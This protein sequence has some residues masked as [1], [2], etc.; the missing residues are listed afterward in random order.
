MKRRIVFLAC[1][2]ILA[3]SSNSCNKIKCHIDPNPKTPPDT[4]TTPSPDTSKK[5]TIVGFTNIS[6]TAFPTLLGVDFEDTLTGYISGVAGF[7]VKTVDGGTTWT[8]IS[9][10]SAGDF[11]GLEF[12]SNSVGY[13]GSNNGD[14]FKTSD[15]G[16]TW[17]KVT[18]PNN[19]FGYGSF[20]FINTNTGYAAGGASS[21]NGSLLKTTDNG[22]TWSNI[23]IPGLKSVYDMIFT[24][25]QTGYMCG[26]QNQIF[27]TSDGGNTW[28]QAIINL[29]T[30]P[31]S[32]ILLGKIRFTSTGVGYC[33]GYGTSFDA[34]YILK[35]TDGGNTWNQ[36]PSPAQ[37]YSS[38]DTYTTLFITNTDD[39]YV[40]GG[41]VAQNTETLIKSVDGGSTWSN[42]A[43][44]AAN[45][46]FESCYTEGKAFI[47]GINGTILKSSNK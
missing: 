14:V 9:P 45:R 46:L 22:V 30:A 12:I 20:A 21:T 6:K 27:K 24:N 8:N 23:S 32:P 4:G 44:T 41:N 39:I 34:N 7:L 13:I 28:T 11:Y 25:Q 15:A 40:A 29:T 36:I 10:G 26:Y 18:T 38:A 17:T 1:I 42:V 5:S 47:V 43:N 33:V 19:T 16:S 35:S 3:V 37:A 2:F 31:A